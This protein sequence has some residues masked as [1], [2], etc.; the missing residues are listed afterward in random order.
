ME[1][2]SSQVLRTAAEENDADHVVAI[3]KQWL[4]IRENAQWILVFDNVDNPKLPAIKDPQAYDIR[5]YFPEAHQGSIFI[6]TRSSHLKFGEVVSVKN[7]FDIQECVTTLA[8]TSGRENLDRGIYIIILSQRLYNQ[9]SVRSLCYRFSETARWA[10]ACTS[11][12]G[13]LSQSSF[14]KPERLSSS[15]RIILAETSKNKPKLC[16]HARIGLCI[17]HGTCLSSKYRNK[18]IQLQNCFDFGLTLIIRTSGFNFLLQEV[19]TVLNG[20]LR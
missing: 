17:P 9:V 8:S 6:T 4:S 12:S 20:L 1:H 19:L 5:P 3:I 18:T 14:D 16:Y 15:L 13:S 11:N 10:S 2:P 7:L